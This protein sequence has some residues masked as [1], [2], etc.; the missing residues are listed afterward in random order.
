VAPVAFNP[1]CRACALDFLFE[2]AVIHHTQCGTA[3]LSDA[4][5]RRGAA[6]ATGI[7]EATLKASIVVDPFDTIDID[8]DRLLDA[9]SLSPKVSVSG[10]VYDIS[11]G[12]ITT[13]IAPRHPKSG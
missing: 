10:H 13:S 12:R 4:E 7:P 9:R 5:F 1:R 2:V 6:K 11:T 8:V 3:F